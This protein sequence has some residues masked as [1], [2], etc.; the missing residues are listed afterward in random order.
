MKLLLLSLA[1]VALSVF[2][3]P[4]AAQELLDDVIL[5]SLRVVEDKDGFTNLRAAASLDSKVVGKVLSGSA[6]YFEETKGD[7]VK[8]MDDTGKGRALFIHKSRLKP[9][10]EWKRTAGKP[11]AKKD[12][13]AVKAG[14]LEATVTEAPFVE[15]DHKVTQGEGEK[16]VDG[17]AVWGTDGELPS[18]EVK[19]E[20]KVDGKPVTLPVEAT[21][22]LYQPNHDVLVLLSPAKPGTEAFLYMEASD[23]AGAYGVVWAFKDGKYA[24]RAVFG[25]D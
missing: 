2:A 24:G 5:S 4:V 7:W 14:T 8:V 25:L 13:I 15:K 6:I 16:I 1:A 22:D 23:G 11:S 3:R 21:Q 18:K 12:S 9:V 10:K 20:V 19:L 17:H